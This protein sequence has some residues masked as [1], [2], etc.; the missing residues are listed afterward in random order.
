MTNLNIL[1]QKFNFIKI[2]FIIKCIPYQI[3]YSNIILQIKLTNRKEINI[4]KYL[5]F[6][7]I[8]IESFV[9]LS[10]IT[11]DI[12]YKNCIGIN[13]RAQIYPFVFST[14]GEI[15][16]HIHL[17]YN[18]QRIPLLVSTLIKFSHNSGILEITL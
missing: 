13:E 9:V 16:I 4:F 14:M 10:I 7:A 17:L 3:I 11:Y 5:S 2:A 1:T 8:I 15:A 18:Y 12:I 6:G